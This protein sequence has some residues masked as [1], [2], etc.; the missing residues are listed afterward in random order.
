MQLFWRK[1]KEKKLSKGFMDIILLAEIAWVSSPV[2]LAERYKW[3]ISNANLN[4]AKE[5]R[6]I[7][8][9]KYWK[10]TS[11]VKIKLD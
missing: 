9:K 3:V 4:T 7:G 6:Q 2:D 1:L 8:I 11:Q 10:Y 5:I